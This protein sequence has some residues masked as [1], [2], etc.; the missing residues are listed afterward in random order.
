M[1]LCFWFFDFVH[2]YSFLPL[3]SQCMMKFPKIERPE[4]I[5]LTSKVFFTTV[6]VFCTNLEALSNPVDDLGCTACKAW[7]SE[8]TV[9]VV[10][11]FDYLIW[12]TNLHWSIA[13]A[14]YP[15]PSSNGS[16]FSQFCSRYSMFK[17]QIHEAHIKLHTR[18]YSRLFVLKK[19]S[20]AKK[21]SQTK[22]R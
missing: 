15:I 20:N 8:G 16:S 13:C 12:P 4:I 19:L 7:A 22:C 11:L 3:S 17:G 5:A 10:V 14:C 6:W 2:C 21:S 1:L 9:F 18:T